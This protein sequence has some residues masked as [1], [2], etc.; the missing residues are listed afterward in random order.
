MLL[1]AMCPFTAIEKQALLE[2]PNAAERARTLTS[3][4]AMGRDAG[5]SQTPRL[6]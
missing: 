1:A 5:K 2:A 4:L 3:L 6:N